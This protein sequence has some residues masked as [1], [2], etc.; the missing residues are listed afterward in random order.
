MIG[1]IFQPTHLLF[2]LVVALLVLG[3]KRLPEAG[4]ALGKGIRDFKMA[5][6]GEEHDHTAVPSEAP[7]AAPPF[8]TPPVASSVSEASPPP[9][10]SPAA[11]APATMPAPEP[12]T[13]ADDSTVDQS[14]HQPS[15]P[16]Q[17]V[18]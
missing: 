13:L 5:I 17:P 11:S 8:V 18:G 6:G 2:I 12:A 3:P 4:R 10:V 14:T 7:V 9:A 16:A 15:E 1:D